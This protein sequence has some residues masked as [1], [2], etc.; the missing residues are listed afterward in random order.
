[1]TIFWMPISLTIKIASEVGAQM[2]L[3]FVTLMLHMLNFG[4][5]SV[6]Q[7]RSSV[8]MGIQSSDFVRQIAIEALPDDLL[9]KN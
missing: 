2:K 1:M 7:S 9:R 8:A 4:S 3:T 6:E 5:N